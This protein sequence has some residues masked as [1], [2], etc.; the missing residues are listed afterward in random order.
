MDKDETREQLINKLAELRQRI[1][2]LE[3]AGTRHKRAEEQ[4]AMGRGLGMRQMET[5]FEQELEEVGT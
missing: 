5:G 4:L 3:A 2:E 1:A